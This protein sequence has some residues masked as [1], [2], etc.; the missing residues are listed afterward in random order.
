MLPPPFLSGVCNLHLHEQP[1]CLWVVS[2]WAMSII[3]VLSFTA[4]QP[5]I[6]F[7]CLDS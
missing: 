6:S 7:G 4:S 1:C 5:A 3:R 2:A